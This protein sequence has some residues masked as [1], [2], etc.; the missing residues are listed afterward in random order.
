MWTP[1]CT[2]L[3]LTCLPSHV[4]NFTIHLPTP[5]TAHQVSLCKMYEW[6]HIETSQPHIKVATHI[7]FSF[8][9]FDILQ[10]QTPQCFI[11][12][13]LVSQLDLKCKILRFEHFAQIRM[14]KLLHASPLSFI[15][16]ILSID[17]SHQLWPGSLTPLEK[18]IYTAWRHQNHISPLAQNIY[19]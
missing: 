17:S 2:L 8:S 5:L 10:P 15:L 16:S 1:C 9:H 7:S 19:F 4:L 6:V 3:R 12:V 11:M 18:S 13:V 14:W